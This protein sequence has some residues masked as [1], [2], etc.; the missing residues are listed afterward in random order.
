VCLY[1]FLCLLS[2]F[3][4]CSSK[5]IQSE[6]RFP[7]PFEDVLPGWLWCLMGYR[8][9]KVFAQASSNPIQ[10]VQVK[11][12]GNEPRLASKSRNACLEGFPSSSVRKPGSRVIRV[13]S[14][15]KIYTQALGEFQA[16]VVDRGNFKRESSI[17]RVMV[18]ISNTMRS[19]QG[20]C[21]PGVSSS[22]QS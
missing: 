11:L 16:R 10:A 15:P 19:N 20:L 3:P 22:A 14:Y 13:Q 8:A 18:P 4:S 7:L 9:V 6:Q 1:P 5:V 12:S 17:Q 21:D 2:L